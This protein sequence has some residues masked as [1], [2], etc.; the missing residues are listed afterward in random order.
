MFKKL[1][2]G[3]VV[4]MIGYFAFTMYES[5]DDY[6]YNEVMIHYLNWEHGKG[7][8]TVDIIEISDEWI[9]YRAY[10]YGKPFVSG[11]VRRT[12]AIDSLDRSLG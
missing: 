9:S 7:D 1:L 12:Y 11:D 4:A 6:D 8:Y 10:K 2:I 3:V 5:K